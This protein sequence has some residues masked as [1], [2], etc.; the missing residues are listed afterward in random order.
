MKTQY[1]T[2]IRLIQ[3]MCCAS[4]CH[5][6][7]M[8]RTLSSIMSSIE[9][10]LRAGTLPTTL[11]DKALSRSNDSGITTNCGRFLRKILV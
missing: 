6:S 5:S 1:K 7:V 9:A 3:S 11:S 4:V 2:Q 8:D 10:T